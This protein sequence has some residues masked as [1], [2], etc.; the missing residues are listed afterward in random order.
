MWMSSKWSYMSTL[1]SEHNNPSP[2]VV[3]IVM[4]FVKQSSLPWWLREN[5]FNNKLI[6]M[7]ILGWWLTNQ[8]TLYKVQVSPRPGGWP[9]HIA[10]C[11][12]IHVNQSQVSGWCNATYIHNWLL[13]VT[14]LKNKTANG[15]HRILE[16]I[17]RIHIF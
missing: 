12:D 10:C 3:M 5:L 17:E 1:S 7:H 14:W 4:Q 9:N 13:Y 15:H 6:N 2:L 11:S 8:R 16:Y